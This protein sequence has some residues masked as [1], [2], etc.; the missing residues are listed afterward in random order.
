MD[1]KCFIT[2]IVF[3]SLFLE[4]RCKNRT[5]SFVSSVFVKVYPQ[6]NILQERPLCPRLNAF[7]IFINIDEV[8]CIWDAQ[9]FTPT[10][11][12]ESAHF[13]I[14]SNKTVK[15]WICINLIVGEQ[16][17]IVTYFISKRLKFCSKL[18]NNIIFKTKIQQKCYIYLSLFLQVRMY[19]FSLIAL[20]PYSW[21]YQLVL[22]LETLQ[23]GLLF[24]KV[25]LLYCSTFPL[26]VSYFLAFSI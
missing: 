4:K 7:L 9:F 11:M 10:K 1:Y 6:S 8:I 23:Q 22:I 20:F 5:C 25:V 24:Q 26:Q 15:L 21:N 12:Y 13:S 19:F 16:E 17:L 18:I 2:R 14:P 3:N